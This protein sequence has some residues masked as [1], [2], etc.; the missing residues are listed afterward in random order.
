MPRLLPV[1][2]AALAA[3]SCT[4]VTVGDI[5]ALAEKARRGDGRAARALVDAMAAPDRDVS[6]ASYQAVLAAGE[7]CK[8]EM[9]KRV[10]SRDP[11]DFEAS[12]AALANLG[13]RR[14]VPDLVAVL[15][16]RGERAL[17]AAW[18]LGMIG[19]SAG[20][21]PLAA[22]LADETPGLRKAAVR[23]LVRI[24]PSVAEAVVDV[25]SGNPGPATERAAIR[26]LG[27][28]RAREAVPRLLAA[29]A[30]NRDAAVWALG[31]INDKTAAASV[32][33]AMDDPRWHVRREAAQALGSLGDRSDI[34]LLRRALSDRETVVREWAAR[35][36]TTL[37]G[38]D[39]L[40]RD[41]DGK[42]VPPYNLYH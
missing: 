27:E 33:E 3:V 15:N 25:W 18:A 24:G 16:E 9:R 30:E 22:A 7:T 13:E 29:R 2:L 35:S 41:E 12:A 5:P 8:A 32:R 38:A 26:V 28:I 37:S 40:Y 6:A 11:A 10:R 14:A 19:D 1:A 21:S 36:L 17:T 23:A 20:V 31:R 34:P 39:I 4:G 42:M